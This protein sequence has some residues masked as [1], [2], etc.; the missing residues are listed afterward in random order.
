M[1][2]RMLLAAALVLLA[3]PAGAQHLPEPGIP[4]GIQLINISKVAHDKYQSVFPWVVVSRSD[5]KLVAVAWRQW[6]LP[7][8]T[9][10]PNFIAECHVAISHDGGHSFTDTD[11]MKYLRTAGGDNGPYH[12]DAQGMPR[13]NG[14]NAPYAAIANDGTIYA[15]GSVY[16]TLGTLPPL[17]RLKAGRVGVSVSKD[18]GKSWSPIKVGIRLDRL[19]DGLTGL[20]GG[21]EPNPDTPWDGAGGVVDP[22]TG[23]F[24]TA[25]GRY[26]AATDDKGESFGTVYASRGTA[27]AAFGTLIAANTVQERADAKCPCLVLSTST[28]KGKSWTDHLVAQADQY[29]ATGQVRYPIAA[30]NPAKAGSYA[31]GVYAPDQKSVKVYYSDDYGQN[32]KMAA[33]RPVPAS[34]LYPAGVRQVD[35]GYTSD[36]HVLVTW[37]TWRN[38]AA[39][40]SFV[41]M[42][43]GDSFGPTVKITPELSIDP[44]SSLDTWYNGDFTNWVVGNNTDAFVAFVFAPKG[45]NEDTWLARVPLSLLR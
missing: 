35:V 32:W 4:D 27:S 31:I 30:A 34:V 19:A 29:N 12:A 16:T 21:M 33:P 36:G 1:K 39:H 13:L 14:C 7:L 40:N 3:A 24:Y 44:P 9:D 5:P 6:G 42:M 28:G 17:P 10:S 38:A 41:A 37:R 20:N 11:L 8:D 43:T 15:G 2:P 26:I 18:S 23:T 25:T 22:Q 45:Q